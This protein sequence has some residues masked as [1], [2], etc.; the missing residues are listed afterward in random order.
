M[1][2]NWTTGGTSARGLSDRDKAFTSTFPWRADRPPVQGHLPA[3]RLAFTSAQRQP[4][5]AIEQGLPQQVIPDAHILGQERE[6]NGDIAAPEA[7]AG[8][9]D[10]GPILR[11]TPLIAGPSQQQGEVAL[12]QFPQGVF[13][14]FASRILDRTVQQAEAAKPVDDCR[15]VWDSAPMS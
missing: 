1:P 8:P 11:T 2:S 9:A 4:Q 5:G 13:E 15:G 12:E 7:F 3:L 14:G 6:I 10:G